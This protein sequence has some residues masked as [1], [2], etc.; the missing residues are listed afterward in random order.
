MRI[1]FALHGLLRVPVGG[2][3]IVYEFANRLTARGH[4]VSLVHPLRSPAHGWRPGWKAR[5]KDLAADVLRPV[6]WLG[7]LRATPPW[8]E[9]SPAVRSLLVPSL[10]SEFL[11]AADCLVATAWHTAPWVA[12]AA[13]SRGAKVYFVQE[14]ESFRDPLPQVSRT[15]DLP[16][17]KIT[18]AR[19]TEERI[20]GRGGRLLG[21]VPNALGPAYCPVNA[22][23]GRDPHHVSMMFSPARIKAAE[24]GVAA[25]V[26]ARE[27]VP[28]L[29][30]EL[31]GAFPP[32][33]DLPPW[34]SYLRS[35]SDA[36]VIHLYNRS[37]LFLCSSR[38]EGWGLPGFE[39]MAC[40]AALVSTDNLGV[41][42]Y[43]VDGQTAL[44]S[45]PGDPGT[46][47]RNLLQLLHDPARR[48]EIARRGSEHVRRFTWERS[49]DAM[50][51]C[52]ERARG[53]A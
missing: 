20:K 13:R 1:T 38:I 16:I 47:A 36:E 46:L 3:R 18:A 9:I 44:L 49:V 24:E 33:K 14:D 27:A 6:W 23:E 50:T 8:F 7:P 25:L 39:A 12:R 45:P 30:V 21:R 42:E 48:I 26:Q 5:L 32:P 22:I 15:Y 28:S 29:R 11:P 4:A 41:R 43:A 31:F 51:D 52:L 35:P 40:G 37:A 53:I 10:E 19:W 34:I 17:L 2:L